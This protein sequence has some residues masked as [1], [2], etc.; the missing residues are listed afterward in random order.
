MDTKRLTVPVAEK[1]IGEKLPV[2]DHG[3]V[4]L[5]EYLGGD[6][7]IVDAAR[8]SFGEEARPV[9]DQRRLIRYLL[10]HHHTSPLEQVVMTVRCKMPIFVARQMVRTRTAR[11]N[12]ISARYS[13]LPKEFYVP[14][15]ERVQ[16]Q[17][18]ANKQG[19]NGQHEKAQVFIDGISEACT[20]LMEGYELFL[21][22][23]ISREL[24]R[25][26]L[27]LNTYTAWTWQIDLNNLLHF[28][29][30]RE[31]EH[32][33]WEIQQYANALHQIAKAVAPLAL[34][35]FRDYAQ[36]AVT[37][38]RIEMQVLHASGGT[39]FSSTKEYAQV[40]HKADKLFGLYDEQHSA[41]EVTEFLNKLGIKESS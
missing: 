10:S 27:P 33:Q 7:T 14:K 3:Y 24:A 5:I 9:K 38:S 18:K 1:L 39:F 11:L 40:W 2:L 12:E 20:H 30:L 31:D 4:Q 28:L 26:A 35:A 22:Q 29:Y 37:F 16:H 21:E 6:A 34:E 41:R 32:A 36:E 23:D 15:P 25:I 13:P 8:V 19:S 17:S